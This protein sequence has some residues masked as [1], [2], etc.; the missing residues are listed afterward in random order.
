MLDDGLGLGLSELDS[1]GDELD[2]GLVD[3]DGLD[4]GLVDDDDGL[5]DGLVDDDG[6][7]DGLV[8]VAAGQV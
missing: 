5:D 4:E 6:L 3:D 1:D 2:D 8:E 7:D